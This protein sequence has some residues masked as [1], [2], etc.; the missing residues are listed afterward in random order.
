MIFLVLVGAV[1]LGVPVVF[2]VRGV[3]AVPEMVGILVTQGVEWYPLWKMPLIVV[4]YIVAL[5]TGFSMR[6]Y[7]DA[8]RS[9]RCV[10][11][12]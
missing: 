11:Q 6:F 1:V 8:T 4:P 7:G 3:S 2:V 10:R 9:P 5:L 12:G